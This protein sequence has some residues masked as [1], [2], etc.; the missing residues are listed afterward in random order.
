MRGTLELRQG[1]ASLMSGTMMGGKLDVDPNDLFVLSGAGAVLDVLFHCIADAGD[2]VLIP[3]P[4]YP[5]FD[6]DLWV[7]YGL[8]DV[9]GVALHVPGPTESLV[10]VVYG[11]SKDFC[12]S[13]LRIGCLH[14]R[15]SGLAGAVKR[16]AYYASVPG[17]L[18]WAVAQLLS[19]GT[20]LQHYLVENKRLLRQSYTTLTGSSCHASSP[21][22]FRL[23]Y[24]W[25][26]LD[27]LPVA[28]DRI[29]AALKSFPKLMY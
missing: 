8:L 10:H 23:C 20:W 11:M 15:N 14:T 7:L 12:A 27:A 4:Y 22:C 29:A 5:S 2:A 16:L 21:G 13:G 28:V 25:P 1:I 24:A 9:M 3:A 18:Q 17:P 19:D 26:S 6:S